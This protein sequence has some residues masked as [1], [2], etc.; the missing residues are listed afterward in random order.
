MNTRYQDALKTVKVHAASQPL[1]NISNLLQESGRH[2][3]FCV[4]TA[5]LYIDLSRSPVNAED[6]S[7]LL[8][9][10]RCAQLEQ[11][12]DAM[13]EGQIMNPT[14]GRRVWHS[15]LRA[16]QAP[17]HMVDGQPQ[18]HPESTK[19]FEEVQ[20]TLE[21]MRSFCA[22]FHE[23]GKITDIVHVGIGGSYLGPELICQ[24]LR[25]KLQKQSST[26]QA[27][28]LQ[29]HFVANVDPYAWDRLAESL[30]PATTLVILAS[31]SWTTPETTLNAQ[32]LR[33]WFEKS[34][35]SSADV[36]R[37]WVA[38]TAKPELA[39][40][41]GVPSE[42]IF[43]FADWVGGRFSV[44][45]AIGLPI[46][47]ACGIEAFD[48]LLA[49]ARAMDQH[50][51]EAPLEKNAP[52]MMALLSLWHQ[53]H[54]RSQSEA[55]IPYA[56]RLARLPAFLQQLQMESNGKRV[57]LEG[58]PIEVPS[59]PVVWGEPGTDSQHSFFQA[60]HHS[61]QAQPIDFILVRDHES[62]PRSFFLQANALAQ[63]EA[64][65]LGH[66]SD[67]PHR[68]YPGN[69]PCLVFVLNKLDARTL[70][71]LLALYEHK[72]AALGWILNINSFDQFGVELGKVIA[73]Q[74]EPLLVNAN[75]AIPESMN[76][77]TRDLVQYLRV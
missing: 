61:P 68:H 77:S 52:I 44:W 73:K 31:K 9:L 67:D 48:D 18:I 34:G 60:L 43:P 58:R 75:Q 45:S 30:T 14:E 7:S 46:M 71:A 36:S 22:K 28:A 57:D 26:L 56:Q 21:R 59:A 16:N 65:S 19:A 27:P 51:Q 53:L 17:T 24:A 47:L 70:G 3:R 29:V 12:R 55:V 5:G 1:R 6:W 74:F 35:L 20:D 50:F 41:S 8:Q 76:P 64:L 38:V 72:T 40:S 66:P 54:L 49:G 13:F 37:H 2:K 42:H 11:K 4:S 63:I 10:A 33:Q 39:Q 62:D 69:R 32:A 25:R 23:E 15:L